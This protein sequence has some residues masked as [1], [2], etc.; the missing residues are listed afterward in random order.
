MAKKTKK[1]APR[2]I[3]VTTFAGVYD[4]EEYKNL[5]DKYKSAMD[6][7]ELY[8]SKSFNYYNDITGLCYEIDFK[9][10]EY[11]LEYLKN[12]FYKNQTS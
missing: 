5:K 2:N 12:T 1:Q 10:A 8:A 9:L 3:R 6:L 7:G 11:L 4:I